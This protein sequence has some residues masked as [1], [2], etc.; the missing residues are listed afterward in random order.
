MIKIAV[1]ILNY[2]GR[3]LLEKFLPAVTRYSPQ[4]TVF[5]ADNAS[6]DDS[7][8]FLREHYPLIQ[9]IVTPSNMG[10]C[11]GYN[12]ALR[13][14]EAK[15]YVLLN[16]DVEVTENWIT[17]IETLMDANAIV[18]AVQPKVLSYS[19]RKK[20]EYAGAAGG[21]IDSL[22]YPFC[23]GRVFDFLEEDTGQYNDRRT[24]FWATGACLF[25]RAE[26]FHDMSGF[27]EDF[28]AHMEEIDLCWK[29]ARSGNE[30]M[31]EPASVVYH[32]GGGTLSANNPTKTFYNYR[33]GLVMLMKHLPASAL[34]WKVPT[35]IVLDWVSALVLLARSVPA[36]R[37][38]LR[39]HASVFGQLGNIM[40]KRRILQKQLG[41]TSSLKVYRGWIVVDFF[42]KGRKRYSALGD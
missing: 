26:R 10:Y 29:L 6:T 31:V 2:N 1:V 24:I 37:A 32:V 3:S 30:V 28:F 41:G 19:D 8:S 7:V 15:Y 27:D 14:V 40:G 5:V 13:R 20:F 42:L 33:N 12:F 16:N 21:M 36:A 17:P 39:A 18:A 22:G 11:G 34:W 35:R 4:A 9:I 38:V 25:I 23:R